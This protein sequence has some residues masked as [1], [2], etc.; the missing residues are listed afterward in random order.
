MVK[1]I[2]LLLLISLFISPIV[3]AIEQRFE[4]IIATVVVGSTFRLSIDK[5][6][7][8]FGLIEPGKRV[9]LYPERY[10]NQITTLSNNGKTWYLKMSIVG[11][12]LRGPKGSIIPWDRLKWQV[13]SIDGEGIKQEGWQSFE[14]QP[15][16][17]YISS[18]QDN[19]GKEVN[20]CLK[21]ALDTPADVIAGYYQTTIIYTMSETP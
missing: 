18:P 16:L 11:G 8:D 12:G 4:D 13:C 14:E 3:Y 7:L 2:F 20:I 19:Q 15:V 1:K 6:N 10:Y 9:E 17:V 21:Y 5:D